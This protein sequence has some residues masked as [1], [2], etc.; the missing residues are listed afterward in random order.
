MCLN[1]LL[2]SIWDDDSF[3][4][5]KQHLINNLLPLQVRFSPNFC[6]HTWAVTGGGAG[7]VRLHCLRGTISMPLNMTPETKAH[8]R[9]LYPLEEPEAGDC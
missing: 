9:A 1:K 3:K 4:I 6:C 8:F 2:K 7:L 5:Y